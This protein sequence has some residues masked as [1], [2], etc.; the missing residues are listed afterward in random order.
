MFSELFLIIYWSNIYRGEPIMLGI[1]QEVSI[2]D[3][4]T[5]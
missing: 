2:P 1:D 5:K 4:L 3:M